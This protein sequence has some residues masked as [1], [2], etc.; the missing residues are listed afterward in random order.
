[1]GDEDEKKRQEKELLKEKNKFIEF[2]LQ[3]EESKEFGFHLSSDK[4]EYVDR[5][6]RN[7]DDLK[8]LYDVI[9]IL[10]KIK[11]L[12]INPDSFK[13]GELKK[14]QIKKSNATGEY[15]YG[16]EELNVERLIDFFYLASKPTDPSPH[17]VFDP[18][19]LPPKK[20]RSISSTPKKEKD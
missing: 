10:Y 11:Y 12:G 8:E 20:E 7:E 4:S 18:I 16:D 1:M 17:P 14:L 3:Q 5:L 19:Q 6:D 2:I 13:P 9:D 15:V